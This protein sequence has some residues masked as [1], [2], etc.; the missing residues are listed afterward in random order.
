M[1]KKVKELCKEKGISVGI[2]RAGAR[3]FKRE[4]M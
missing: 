4:R 2:F 3:L 1:Y